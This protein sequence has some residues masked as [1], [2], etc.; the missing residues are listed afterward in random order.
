MDQKEKRRLA[1]KKWLSNPENRKKRADYYREWYRKNGRSRPIDYLE[2]MDRWVK[3]HPEIIKAHSKLWCAIRSGKVK[4]SS[5]C[6][7]CGRETRTYGH[8][9]DY[10]KPLKVIWVCASCHKKIHVALT[11]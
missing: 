10:S 2:A 7:V 8:H 5:K 11:P 6:Q 9:K 1:Q 3:N 4:K